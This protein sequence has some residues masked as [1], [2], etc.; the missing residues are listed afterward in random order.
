MSAESQTAAG[1]AGYPGPAVPM[2]RR[3]ALARE[4]GGEHTLSSVESLRAP[5]S[6]RPVAV[7]PAPVRPRPAA[8]APVGQVPAPSATRSARRAAPVKPK[9]TRST[10]GQKTRPATASARRQPR[11]SKPNTAA[12]GFIRSVSVVGLVAGLFAT[13]AVPAYAL[14]DHGGS[15]SAADMFT[16]SQRYAQSVAVS[17]LTNGQ[18]A[19]TDGYSS[20]SG[21]QVVAVQNSSYRSSS[22]PLVR[23]A[24]DDYPWWNY[25]TEYSGGG[26]SPL[27]YY[28]RECVDFVAWRLN[29]DAGSTGAPWKWVWNNLASGSAYTWYWYWK[30]HGWPTSSTP[31][32]GAVAWFTYNHVA[33]V[34][35][36]NADGTVNI[37]EYNWQADHLYHARTIQASDAI[38][39]YPPS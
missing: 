23:S 38:Y 37:E 30:S 15:F 25:A 27:G 34:N 22:A 20:V 32:P 10:R 18:S 8:A 35:S 36:V 29:R 2:T 13:V 3:E 39:L 11:K 7:P 28:Y 5:A 12:L 14:D 6:A 1:G 17:G 33:Y 16:T 4:R 31:V 19:S 21:A 24:N 9:S 26:L